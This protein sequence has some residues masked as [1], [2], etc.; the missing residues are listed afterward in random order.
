MQIGT[1]NWNRTS[2]SP[3]KSRDSISLNYGGIKL[4]VADVR[5]ARIVFRHSAYETEYAS[6]RCFIRIQVIKSPI[7][8][9]DD[10]RPKIIDLDVEV[11]MEEVLHTL[12]KLRLHMSVV[13][14][15]TRNPPV[16]TFNRIRNISM[17]TVSNFAAFRST[18]LRE[19]HMPHIHLNQTLGIVLFHLSRY[20]P[21]N[22][23]VSMVLTVGFEPTN[24]SV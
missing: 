1:A 20:S 24:L 18:V 11:Q 21:R 13:V 4:L 15:L 2:I 14:V 12:L 23:E 16:S 5:V 7:I 22:A 3:G 19:L 9:T 6:L 17:H 10:V 8:I